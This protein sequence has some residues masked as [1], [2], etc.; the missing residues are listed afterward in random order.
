MRKIFALLVIFL[1][2]IN[3]NQAFCAQPHDWVWNVLIIPPSTGWE[4]EP[5]KSISTALSWC[6]RE[7]SESSSGI[8]GHDI[9]F[10]RLDLPQSSDNYARDIEI[11]IDEHT[12][13]VMSFALEPDADRMFTA[14]LAGSNVPLLIAGGENVL[15]D[16]A[17]RPIANIFA[18][19]L[20][21]DYRCP[22]FAEYAKAI[23]EKNKR[24][25][26]AASRFTVNQER[27][28]K[29]CY[30]MLDNLGF[31]PMPYW[32]DASV[33]DTYYMMSEEIESFE[34]EQAGVV[35]SFM[36]GM[37]AREI[38]RNFM[39]IRTSWR[40]WN[41]AEP[42]RT[43]LSCRGMIFADQNILL[44]SKGGF[45]ETKRLLW[46]TRAM[47][48]NDTPAA[49]RAIALYEWLKR[50]IDIMPQPVDTLPRN[51]LL[52]NLANVRNIPF[53]NQVL[54]ISPN[55]HRPEARDVYIVEVRDR[56]YSEV[57]LVR[58]NGL[59]YIPAY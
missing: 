45:I 33:Q 31:M 47:A 10:V 59:V 13:A 42:D 21:R 4:A 36:G 49:G 11:N 14:R 44:A 51:Q 22:A 52:R 12:A 19:D 20:Y 38:W 24:I 25:A 39:R 3:V 1:C 6:E 54:N 55:L 5:G 43:Y 46:R 2:A 57:D 35:I 50:A 7:I 28:A 56:E 32:T 58:V 26:L 18:L 9:K 41:C 34:G 53:G 37:G 29:I 27:E 17:G 15:I 23:Y 30:A 40:L 8:G 16:R 48:I